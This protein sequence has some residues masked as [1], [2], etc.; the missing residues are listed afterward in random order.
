MDVPKL[1]FDVSM[2]HYIE[3]LTKIFLCYLFAVKTS[4]YYLYTKILHTLL[5]LEND[6]LCKYMGLVW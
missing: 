5:H 1:M 2:G 3:D 6:F 4:K